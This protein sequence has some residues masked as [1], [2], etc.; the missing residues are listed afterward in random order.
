MSRLSRLAAA[1]VT[2]ALLAGCAAAVST[3]AA[4]RPH[5]DR[6]AQ[7]EQDQ[8]ISAAV[9]YRLVQAPG[10]SATDIL[11]RTQHGR[12][13]LDGVV[14]GRAAARAAER[15]AWSVD[16]VRDVIVRLRVRDND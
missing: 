2:A 6:G 9:N 10:V 4:Q 12:V 15:A 3:G 5:A 13:T 11:V 1:L 7:Q 14:P 8:R 16:G